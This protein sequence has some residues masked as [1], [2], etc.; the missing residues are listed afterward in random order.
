MNTLHNNVKHFKVL[1]IEKGP[2][3]FSNPKRNWIG[4]FQLMQGWFSSPIGTWSDNIYVSILSFLWF[5]L[6]HFEN[7]KTLYCYQFSLI[8][9]QKEFYF[10]KVYHG[11][12]NICAIWVFPEVYWKNIT[13]KSNETDCDPQHGECRKKNEKFFLN[14]AF[15]G[16]R[17]SRRNTCEE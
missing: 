5:F 7:K 2:I 12:K 14:C 16:H 9:E 10:W 15:H 11:N 6:A 8:E 13:C 3:M 17:R 1:Y 4:H